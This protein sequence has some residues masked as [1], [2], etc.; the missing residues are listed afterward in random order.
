MTRENGKYVENMQTEMVEV[1]FEPV[2]FSSGWR[3]A[4]HCVRRKL[5]DIWSAVSF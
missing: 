5:L 2:A 1:P 4:V 3:R